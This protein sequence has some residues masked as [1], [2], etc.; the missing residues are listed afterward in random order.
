MTGKSVGLWLCVINSLFGQNVAYVV[1][2]A[3]GQV[4]VIDLAQRRV[5]ATI[6]SGGQA[7]EMLILPNNRIAVVPNQAARSVA[8]LDLHR[9]K[10]AA[11]LTICKLTFL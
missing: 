3:L 10:R 4:D 2:N 5:S 6:P 7:S 9:Q 1:D 8:F 11:S